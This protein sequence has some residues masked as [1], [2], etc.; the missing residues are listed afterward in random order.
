MKSDLKNK[1]LELLEMDDE[2]VESVYPTLNLKEG[3]G[4]YDGSI[5]EMISRNE[6]WEAFIDLAKR[7]KVIILIQRGNSL[8]E[9]PVE[10]VKEKERERYWFRLV[11]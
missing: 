10:L 2:S 9:T 11:H 1:I 6:I 5:E 8:E 4:L 7:R 3:Q